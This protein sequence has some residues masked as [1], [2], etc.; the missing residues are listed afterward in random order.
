M[1]AELVMRCRMLSGGNRSEVRYAGAEE[2]SPMGDGQVDHHASA[3]SKGLSSRQ[4]GVGGGTGHVRP[5][6]VTTAM[7][8][9][10]MGNRSRLPRRSTESMQPFCRSSGS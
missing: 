2:A 5:S 3:R 7:E 10:M 8:R 1:G 9:L 4:A 6:L